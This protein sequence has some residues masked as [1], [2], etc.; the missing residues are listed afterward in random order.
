LS[1]TQA[2]A[3]YLLKHAHLRKGDS[4]KRGQANYTI[5]KDEQWSEH[6]AVGSETFVMTT[7]EKFSIKAKGRETIETNGRYELGEPEISYE[8]IPTPENGDP[9]TKNVYFWDD[10]P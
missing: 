9:R 1:S 2:F 10:I 7:M 5:A 6:V 3:L 4:K 8:P